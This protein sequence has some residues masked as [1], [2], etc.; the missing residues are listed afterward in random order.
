MVPRGVQQFLQVA[1]QYLRKGEADSSN[2][3]PANVYQDFFDEEVLTIREEDLEGIYLKSL[4]VEVLQQNEDGERFSNEEDLESTG[5]GVNKSTGERQL[6]SSVAAE[7][8]N[9]IK[10]SYT[11][12]SSGQASRDSSNHSFE[13]SNTE[14]LQKPLPPLERSQSSKQHYSS[15]KPLSTKKPTSVKKTYYQ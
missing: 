10:A 4:G 9:S 5:S 12:N 15:L 3:E 2:T 1:P 7:I 11:P 13:T 14:N 8:A 6:D